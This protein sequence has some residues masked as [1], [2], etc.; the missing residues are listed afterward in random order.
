MAPGETV[1][2]Q[3]F[4]RHKQAVIQREANLLTKKELAE[5]AGLAAAAM[6][7]LAQTLFLQTPSRL[8]LPQHYGLTIRGQMENYHGQQWSQAP[9][10]HANDSS[11]I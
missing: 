4:S 11:W 6:L 5:H 3:V 10:A 9:P 7:N 1:V 8:S 2:L